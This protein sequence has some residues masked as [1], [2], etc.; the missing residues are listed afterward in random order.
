MVL[1]GNGWEVVDLG[2]DVRSEKILSS[3]NEN[4][5]KAIRL[6]TLLTTTMLNMK[7]IVSDI[8]NIPWYS[9]CSW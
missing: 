6:S 4:E 3:I 8:K 2:I 5:I 1:E 9:C 7:N